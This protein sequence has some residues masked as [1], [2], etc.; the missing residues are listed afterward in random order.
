MVCDLV[1]VIAN[2]VPQPVGES[3]RALADAAPDLVER[4]EL[5][6]GHLRR[7]RP[8]VAG[9]LAEKH[10]DILV[11][12]H[13]VIEL[14]TIAA[15]K[16]ERQRAGDA[17]LLAEPSAGAHNRALARARMAAAGV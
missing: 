1:T 15:E 9:E 11:L 17:E 2:V 12:M 16:S 10:I 8:H 7:I 6:V 4:H 5:D 3:L 14:G 13:A